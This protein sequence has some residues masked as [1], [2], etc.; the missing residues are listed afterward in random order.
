[1][2]I[3]G[4]RDTD[5]DFTAMAGSGTNNIGEWIGL[6]EALKMAFAY[7]NTVN[8]NVRIR[9]YGDSQLVVRQFNGQYEVKKDYFMDYY[10]EARRLYSALDGKVRRVEWIPRQQ[11]KE[12]DI[13][14]K[15]AIK[16]YLIENKMI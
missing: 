8:S 6:V 15:K 13:L 1:M 5:F 9:I 3:D 7:V 4:E 10:K 11:N 16:D 14:S 2:W 12:A